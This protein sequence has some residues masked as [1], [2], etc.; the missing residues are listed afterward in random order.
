MSTSTLLKEG[1]SHVAVE[2]MWCLYKLT[3]GEA[4]KPEK[5]QQGVALLSLIEQAG[6]IKASDGKDVEAETWDAYRAVRCTYFA[7]RVP[8]GEIGWKEWNE[9]VH[10][11]FQEMFSPAF[12]EKV[13]AVRETLENFLKD[14]ASVSKESMKDVHRF[15]IGLPSGMRSGA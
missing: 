14:P 15:F 8:H 2:T 11:A 6:K 7:E 13:K 9:A 10:R 4:Y 3:R 5:L 12:I 1:L